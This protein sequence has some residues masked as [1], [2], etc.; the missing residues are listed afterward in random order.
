MTPFC[1]NLVT[2]YVL[3]EAIIIVIIIIIII[4]IIISHSSVKQHPPFKQPSTS[5][6]DGSKAVINF[7]LIFFVFYV[8]R[9]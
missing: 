9:T 4:I 7:P 5:L 8:T 6:W 2:L 1:V 3:I